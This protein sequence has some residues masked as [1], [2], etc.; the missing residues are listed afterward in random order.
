MQDF[1]DMR[2]RTPQELA[3]SL[4]T[5]LMVVGHQKLA[6]YCNAILVLSPEHYAIF[7]GGGWRRDDIEAALYEALRR[8]GKDLIRGAGGIGE[9]IDP[10]RGAD[11]VDKFWP[12]HGLLIVL[13]GGRQDYTL[14]SYPVGPVAARANNHSPSH[15]RST[16][17]A[18]ASRSNS[19]TVADAAPAAHAAEEP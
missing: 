11:T 15:G 10:A 6:E 17:D 8:P 3:I 19:R 2:S 5:S 4:A 16:Y 14:L 12:G 13:A 1:I 9:G 7:R 18:L